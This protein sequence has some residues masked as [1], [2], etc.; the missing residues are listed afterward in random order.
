[1]KEKSRETFCPLFNIFEF[2][3]MHSLLD[4]TEYLQMFLGLKPRK[5]P[6]MSPS[7]KHR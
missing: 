4:N 7:G 2:F 1:M 3:L 5:V 6:S